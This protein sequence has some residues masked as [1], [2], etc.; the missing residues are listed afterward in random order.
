MGRRKKLLQKAN[1][2]EMID[3]EHHLL[4]IILGLIQARTKWMLPVGK[5]LISNKVYA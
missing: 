2:K 3:K 4:P 1:N 5:S